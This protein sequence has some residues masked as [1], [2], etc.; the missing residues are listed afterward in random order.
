[1]THFKLIIGV[2]ENL[3][4]KVEAGVDPQ[5]IFTTVNT[6]ERATTRVIVLLLE[7]KVW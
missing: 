5:A 4:V 6:V 3:R 2:E 7:K 1:M